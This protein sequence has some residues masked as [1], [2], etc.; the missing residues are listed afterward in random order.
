MER[1][2]PAYKGDEPYIFVSY[3]H[4]D[5][6]IVY[7]EIQ[8]LHDQGF[9]VWYDE[10]ISPGTVWR[11]ELAESIDG[12]SLFLYFITPQ[13]VDSEHCQREVNYA[14][15]HQKPLLTVHLEETD[16]SSGMDL[17]LSTIQAIL[18]HELT[19]QEYRTKLLSGA[20][21]RIRRGIAVPGAAAPTAPSKP[22]KP[23][24]ALVLAAVV[25][26]SVV[27]GIWGW[28]LG[29]VDPVAPRPLQRFTIELPP[30][31][32]VERIFVASPLAI[33]ADGSRVVFLGRNASHM[34]LYSRA[35]NELAVVPIRGTEPPEGRVYRA[36]S[37]FLSP[38]GEW[39][40]FN[41]FIE[42]TFKKV[43]VTG[44]SPITISSTGVKPGVL[45]V[46]GATWGAN[47]TIVF[48]ISGHA[49][50]M[51]VPAAG[52]TPQPL[53]TPDQGEF[54]WRPHFLPD[55]SALV[56]TVQ[57]ESTPQ[58]QIAVLSMKTGE[59]R[60]LRAGLTPQVT[61]SGHL[62]FHSENAVWAAGFDLNR[63]E[64]TSEPVPVPLDVPA[65][66][67]RLFG[68]AN[69]GTLVYW[70]PQAKNKRI[71]VWVDRDGREEVLPADVENYGYARISPDGERV[72]VGI[73]PAGDRDLWTYSLAR[74]AMT[75]LTFDEA[76]NSMPEWSPDGQRIVF[77]ANPDGASNLFWRAADGSGTV[78]RLTTSARTQFPTAWSSDGQ[79]VLFQECGG[80]T[81]CDLATLSMQGEPRADLLLQTEFQEW[82]A[83]LSP[84]GRWLAY[85]SAE[86]GKEEVYVRPFPDVD[87]GRWQ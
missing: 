35:L 10:G 53:T 30:G 87:A 56:F 84:D 81:Q 85:G 19:D 15:N 16:L 74:G 28:N 48:A 59:H 55:G 22:R 20:S 18:K 42:G 37:F 67:A 14:V 46:M 34:Q 8:W 52:G 61:A 80:D 49:G 60:I 75:R 83:T 6:E 57:H 32:R 17:T 65:G 9:N 27:A 4:A 13:S 21:D 7:P 77:A 62:L 68:V 76:G 47:G 33:S 78:E 71:L 70:N 79:V 39:V 1:P 41:D 25:V 73:G 64:V 58:R 11:N 69:D 31:I 86:L 24:G 5:D 66:I 38:D 40:A 26:G 23:V 3:A 45:G 36:E 72:A 44:G 43:P 50:L 51:Q 82:H 63:L 2:F 29:S 12:S 54:H